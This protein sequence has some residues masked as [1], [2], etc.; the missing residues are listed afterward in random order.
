MFGQILIWVAF[1]SSLFGLVAFATALRAALSLPRGLVHVISDVHGEDAKLR[2]VIN[3]ASGSLR[4]RN[5]SER[6]ST[7]ST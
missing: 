1:L 4:H 3:N 6:D 7:S 2:H 5:G